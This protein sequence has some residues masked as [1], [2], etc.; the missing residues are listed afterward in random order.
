M[1]GEV[2]REDLINLFITVSYSESRRENQV[3]CQVGTPYYVTAQ[4]LDNY[5]SIVDYFAGKKSNGFVGLNS[6]DTSPE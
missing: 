2:L 1:N 4:I 6:L 5:R 3:V